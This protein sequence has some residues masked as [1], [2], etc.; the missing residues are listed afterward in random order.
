MEGKK[1]LYGLTRLGGPGFFLAAILIAFGIAGIQAG[2]GY[3]WL[4]LLLGAGMI[5]LHFT[6]GRAVRDSMNAQLEDE[7]RQRKQGGAAADAP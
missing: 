2:I 6:V 5:V 7:E 4:A 1:F 3:G